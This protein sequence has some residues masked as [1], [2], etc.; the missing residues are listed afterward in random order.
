MGPTISQIVG[1][2]SIGLIAGTV[3]RRRPRI[4]ARGTGTNGGLTTRTRIRRPRTSTA[5]SSSSATPAMVSIRASPMPWPSVGEKVPE[6][7]SPIR[8]P[9][10]SSTVRWLRSTPRSSASNPQDARIGPCLLL[11]EQRV[12]AEEARLAPADR[13]ADPGLHRADRPGRGPGRA[14]HSPSRCAG[15]PG[16]RARPAGRRADRPRAPAPSQSAGASSQVGHQFVAVLA[17]VPGPADP[18]RP[19]VELAVRPGH[20]V[21]VGRQPER[22]QHLGRRRPL[23]R[24]HAEIGVP[25]DDLDAGR[26]PR[27]QGR[28]H[29]SGVGRV[30]DQEHLV[31]RR[32]GRRS[33]RR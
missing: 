27:P 15:C 24:E 26:A 16:R 28:H 3:D 30:G 25:V 6:V 29:G 31:R 11:R 32:P 2:P 12:P 10:A 1:R 8:L 20:V 9:S 22:L 5:I 14:A 21:Q 17:G 7:V 13:P 23:D 4:S 19:P 18:D 33:G